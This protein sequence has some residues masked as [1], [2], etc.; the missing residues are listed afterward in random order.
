[1]VSS[2]FFVPLRTIVRENAHTRPIASELAWLSLN[3]SLRGQITDVKRNNNGCYDHHEN[4][5]I[6][7][8]GGDGD[9]CY[10]RAGPA[11]GY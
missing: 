6:L 1:M 10:R 5:E 4:K 8:G 9:G 3:R 7:F 2:L 11:R